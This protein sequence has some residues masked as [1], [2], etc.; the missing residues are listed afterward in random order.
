MKSVRKDVVLKSDALES[1]QVEKLILLQVTHPFIIQMDHIFAQEARIYFVMQFVKGGELWKHL[2]ELK[3][4]PES[5]TA[6]YAA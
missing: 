2:S 5:R 6:F 3:R 1:L 4:F